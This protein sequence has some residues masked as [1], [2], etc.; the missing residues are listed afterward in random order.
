M[1][2]IHTLVIAA[3]A[4]ALAPA[5]SAASLNDCNQ[6]SK[7]VSE[8]LTNA[9]SGNAAS[10]ARSE[11]KSGQLFCATGMYAQGVARYT[12]ALQLLGKA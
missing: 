4:L 9:P 8:A 10:Q 5:A 3:S 12:K 1:K 11:A 2:F 6:M 7:E